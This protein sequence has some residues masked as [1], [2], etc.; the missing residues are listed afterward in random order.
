MFA[1]FDYP[2]A[3]EAFRGR[4]RERG[5]AL[6]AA[7]G[8]R[9]SLAVLCGNS[10]VEQQVG[11][12]R[13]RPGARPR[14]LFSEL[15]PAAGRARRGVAVPYVPSAPVRRRPAVPPGP[16]R[17]ATTTASAATSGRS[18]DARRAGVRFAAEC[19][20]FANVPD[21]RALEEI[22]GA[23]RRPPSTTRAGRPA[24][25]AT[26][27]Q[28][29]T[30]TTC[31]T[32]TSP[33]CSAS[34]R[35]QLRCT[36]P[37]RYLE[38]RRAV[39]GEV[40]AETFGEWRRAGS[41]CA[42]RARPV[43][44]RPASPGAGW[45]VLDNRGE[46][47]VAY[48]HLRRVLAPVAVWTTDEGARRHRHPRRQRPVRAARQPGCASR[49]TATSRCRSERPASRS[50]FL[51]GSAHAAASKSVLGRFVDVSWAYR[52]GPPGQDVVVVSLEELEGASANAISQCFR[53]PAGRPARA[54][55]AAALGLEAQSQPAGDGT[56]SVRVRSRRLAYAVRVRAP[57]FEPHDDAFSLEPGGER[58]IRLA[59]TLEGVDYTGGE[60]SAANQRG[61]VRIGLAA[62]ESGS[63]LGA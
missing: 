45:G 13:A 4:G 37:E 28:A 50:S 25:R 63:E 43:A 33:S 52:F 2:V 1:N 41:P 23:R 34:I 59:P 40:M 44:A 11:D 49:S 6:L 32:T 55:P 27:A 8:G 19:L 3:D 12:A 56:V 26:P 17:R 36:D 58:L 18:S 30:S 22:L 48:H 39:T 51:P 9:P 24:S 20:A 57:G 54:E 15:L 62:T 35:S 46:P 10:E 60:V 53:F 7:L 16:R 61:R 29:G 31:A 21:E 38:L 14:Q 42:R 5:A 47:K